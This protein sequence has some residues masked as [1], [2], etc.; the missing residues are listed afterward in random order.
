M[1][2]GVSKGKHASSEKRS[3]LD[4]KI[5]GS[6]GPHGRVCSRD[7]SMW[8]DILAVRRDEEVNLANVS[9]KTLVLESQEGNANYKVKPKFIRTRK[10]YM[11]KIRLC[12][13]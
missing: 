9:Q 8:P 6:E 2:V 7:W 10:S 13:A 1:E 4:S 11:L 3:S 12:P 5:S